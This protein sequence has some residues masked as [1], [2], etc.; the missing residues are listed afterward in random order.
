MSAKFQVLGR[1]FRIF[2]TGAFLVPIKIKVD[3]AEIW[4]WIVDSFEDDSFSEGEMCNPLEHA[5]EE[6]QLVSSSADD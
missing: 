3:H 6:V 5:D 1:K 2:T 4:R